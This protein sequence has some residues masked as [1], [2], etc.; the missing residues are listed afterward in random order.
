MLYL[1][2]PSLFAAWIFRTFHIKSHTMKA[3]VIHDHHFSHLFVY[4]EKM[5]FCWS[6]CCLVEYFLEKKLL[7]DYPFKSH[8]HDYQ[9]EDLVM[10][11]YCK[12]KENVNIKLLDGPLLGMNEPILT[13]N[14]TCGY[15]QSSIEVHS[16]Y[17]K[18]CI[19][20]IRELVVLRWD[21]YIYH[22]HLKLPSLFAA[23][24]FWTF[25]NKLHNIKALVILS[26]HDHH[27]SH[28]LVFMKKNEH[29][30]VI[31]SSSGVFSW[32]KTHHSS[33]FQRRGSYRDL[34]PNF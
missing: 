18:F 29:L 32:E 3:L 2:L 17:L 10:A 24:L 25:H 34:C 21:I 30:P 11:W 23:R 5:T 28:L 8:D 19:L 22:S 16:H 33:L 14:T 1:K 31:V 6:L 15:Q 20:K 13:W 26:H 9:W 27:F 7:P 4:M 12:T